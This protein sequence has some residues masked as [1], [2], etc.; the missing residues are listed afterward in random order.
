MLQFGQPG[1]G[2]HSSFERQV[3]KVLRPSS[4][5]INT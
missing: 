3:E 4:V 1:P 5:L 2:I